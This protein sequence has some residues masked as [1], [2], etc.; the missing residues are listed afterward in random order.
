MRHCGENT[1]FV[2]LF[3]LARRSFSKTDT[4]K[5]LNTHFPHSVR[6]IHRK[7]L[8]ERLSE[9]RAAGFVVP[10]GVEG[11]R[12]R[13]VFAR[14]RGGKC[15]L[16]LPVFLLPQF[17][18]NGELAEVLNT[19]FPR[20]LSKTDGPF[21]VFSMHCPLRQF[22]FRVIPRKVLKTHFPPGRQRRSVGNAAGRELQPVEVCAPALVIPCFPCAALLRSRSCTKGSQYPLSSRVS[23]KSRKSAPGAVFPRRIAREG[24]PN[25]AKTAFGPPYSRA[26]RR[27]KAVFSVR[28]PL[29][30]SAFREFK[31]QRF[32]IPTFLRGFRAQKNEI[33]LFGVFPLRDVVFRAKTRERSAK[34]A[35][36]SVRSEPSAAPFSALRTGPAVRSAAAPCI[37]FSLYRS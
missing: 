25:A 11:E 37:S 19:H 33:L 32:S 28:F 9:S 8:R 21:N 16:R 34:P 35:R 13:G 6:K 17:F 3:S 15:T 29:R 23:T 24:A 1:C 18:S 22:F 12:R 5:V 20:I 26:R 4:K 2:S 30:R 14:V 27:G 7:P 31:V 36:L 10:N